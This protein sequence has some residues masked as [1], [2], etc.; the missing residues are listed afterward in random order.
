MAL[1]P[2]C[3]PYV[4]IESQTPTSVVYVNPGQGLRWRVDGVCN[5]CGK[6]WEGAVGPAPVLD[7]PVTPEF[8]GQFEGC[9]LHGEYLDG[10]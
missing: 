9:T 7:S 5:K 8:N 3:D 6:C 10:D 1:T 2:T 4:F